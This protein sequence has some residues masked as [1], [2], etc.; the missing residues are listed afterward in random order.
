MSTEE[1]CKDGQSSEDLEDCSPLLPDFFAVIEG[2]SSYPSRCHLFSCLLEFLALKRGKLWVPSRL[3]SSLFEGTFG[4]YLCVQTDLVTFSGRLYDLSLWSCTFFDV[5][6]I[7][8]VGYR[9]IGGLGMGEESWGSCS[10][11][12]EVC[13]GA[14]C[15]MVFG[16][17]G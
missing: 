11:S 9:K 6:S 2:D 15:L 1:S 12:M 14:G 10:R 16:E 7:S 13:T 4:A 5:F 17:D 8:E 3:L